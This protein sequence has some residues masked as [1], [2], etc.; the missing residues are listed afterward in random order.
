MPKTKEERDKTKADKVRRVLEWLP[1]T[2][3]QPLIQQLVKRLGNLVFF[4]GSDG[5]QLRSFIWS[6]SD[7]VAWYDAAVGLMADRVLSFDEA[8]SASMPPCRSERKEEAK[9]EASA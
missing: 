3:E 7:L 9:V 6:E 5:D 1:Y 8:M 4:V 2:G